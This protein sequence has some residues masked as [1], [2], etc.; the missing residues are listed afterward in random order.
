VGTL[1]TAR[2]LEHLPEVTGAFASGELSEVKVREVAVAASAC[3]EAEPELVAA[4]RTE[5]VPALRERCR[6]VTAASVDPDAAHARIHAGRYLRHH[7][8]TDGAFRMQA[9]PSIDD[10]ARVLAGIEPH[11]RAIIAAERRDGRMETGEAHAA[12]ALVGIAAGEACGPRATVQVRVD[13]SA[14]ARGRA[15]RGEVCEIPGIGPIP[16]SAARRLASDSIVRAVVTEG[17][18]VTAVAHLGRTVPATLRTALEARDPTCA[19]PGCDVRDG[20]EID[21]SDPF[22]RGGPTSL[23]NLDR[24][25]RWHHFLKTHR[26]YRLGGAPGAWTWSG[27][28]PP[29]G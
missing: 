3:P 27:P 16:V 28:D 20:L 25:C 9:R 13:A 29:P 5:T 15:V 22:A 19:V 23:E 21:H 17:A 8:D 1:E 12:D 4:A 7:T 6:R 18:D 2:R 10:G 24:L 26:G 14:L 11:R